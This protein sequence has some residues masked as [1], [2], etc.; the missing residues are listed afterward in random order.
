MKQIKL[1]IKCGILN[2]HN[3]IAKLTTFSKEYTGKQDEKYMLS[4]HYSCKDCDKSKVM[5]VK[6]Y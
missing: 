4:I 2:L 3:Y 6:V 1:F 5:S